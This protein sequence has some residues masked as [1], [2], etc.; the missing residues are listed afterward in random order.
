MLA[1]YLKNNNDNLREYFTKINE[2]FEL[3]NKDT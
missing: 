3:L 1:L 2:G